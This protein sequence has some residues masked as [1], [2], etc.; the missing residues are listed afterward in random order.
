[1]NN[2]SYKE[3]IQ[4]LYPILHKTSGAIGSPLLSLALPRKVS[5]SSVRRGG[6]DPCVLCVLRGGGAPLFIALVR[7]FPEAVPDVGGIN[8]RWNR[9]P[10]VGGEPP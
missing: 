8:C 9:P 10:G 2:K 7:R 4:E 5:S 3:R 6:N 1:M